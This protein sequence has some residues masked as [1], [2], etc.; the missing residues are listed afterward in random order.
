MENKHA[1][2]LIYSAVNTVEVQLKD[3]IQQL[4][5]LIVQSY[6]HQGSATQEAMKR[7]MYD[8]Y[9]YTD[10]IGF[11]LSVQGISYTLPYK[12]LAICAASSH[13]DSPRGHLVRGE[14]EK[15]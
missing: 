3:I 13:C 6:D 10:G 8:F 15:P 9:S 11:N 5:N 4:Y 1:S 2:A 12:T 7:E 14:F